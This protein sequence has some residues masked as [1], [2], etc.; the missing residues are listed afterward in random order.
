MSTRPVAAK[1]TA[2][3]L[4][5]AIE[6]KEHE[7][8]DLTK[9]ITDASML[10]QPLLLPK[11]ST[12]VDY[13]TGGA[14]LF[15]GDFT[16]DR[17]FLEHVVDKVLVYESGAL[18]VQFRQASLFQPVRFAALDQSS[19]TGLVAGRREH[20]AEF[21][22]QK[23]EVTRHSG[24]GAAKNLAV[25]VLHDGEGRPAYVMFTPGV[26]KRTFGPGKY[27]ESVTAPS[28]AANEIALASPA[29]VEPALAT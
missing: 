1:G 19:K 17:K 7:L 22:R 28:G 16:H 12:A 24:A 6:K 14:S 18:V 10:M 26:V 11:Q 2:K 21:Q 25:D 3:S 20:E 4:V 23:A 8:E 9:K 5:G 27:G 15:T 29:G 13:M